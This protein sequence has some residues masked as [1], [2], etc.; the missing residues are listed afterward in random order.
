M[1]SVAQTRSMPYLM[2]FDVIGVPSSNLRSSCSLKVYVVLSAL[3]SGSAAARSGTS[4]RP[5]APGAGA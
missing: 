4:F 3:S 2:S 1:T 5:S